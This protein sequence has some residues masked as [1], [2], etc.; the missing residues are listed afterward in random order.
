MQVRLSLACIVLLFSALLSAQTFRG[1]VTGVVTDSSGAAVPQ[2][3]VK[4]VNEGTGLE[5]NVETDAEGNYTVTELPLGSYAVSA[6]KHGF[7]TRVL[8]GVRVDVSSNQ[9]VHIKLS[10]GEV[11]E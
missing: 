4:V 3:K 9:R 10:P 1:G 5:R 11:Q 6:T 2:A 8:R 7:S